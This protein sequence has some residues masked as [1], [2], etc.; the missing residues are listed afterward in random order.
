[1]VW[2][3]D[4][5]PTPCMWQ[6]LDGTGFTSVAQQVLQP[7]LRDLEPLGKFRLGALLGKVR[8]DDPNT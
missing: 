5:L 3:D 4:A 1:L 6:G 2:A 7:A 8:L